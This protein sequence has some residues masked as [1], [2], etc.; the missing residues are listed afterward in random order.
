MDRLTEEDHKTSVMELLAETVPPDLQKQVGRRNIVRNSDNFG[1]K[2]AREDDP[3]DSLP[4]IQ[5]Q[6]EVKI[7]SVPKR[8]TK[9]SYV[10]IFKIQ[11]NSNLE[12]TA[13][14]LVLWEMTGTR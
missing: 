11:D 1:L 7:E 3:T 13:K 9:N 5:P 8:F 2:T 4:N 10:C 14:S 6:E 12:P